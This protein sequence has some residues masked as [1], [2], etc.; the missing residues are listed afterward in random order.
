[1]KKILL[2]IIALLTMSAVEAQIIKGDMD[3]DG[4]ITRMD[5]DAIMVTYLGYMPTELLQVYTADELDSLYLR[6]QNRLQLIDSR[7]KVLEAQI[8]VEEEEKFTNYAPEH[9][10]AVDLG[11]SVRWAS[12]NLGATAPEDNGSYFAW[13]EPWP[14][15]KYELGNYQY[16]DPED[17]FGGFTKYTYDDGY[18]N[19]VWYD[20]DTF[21]GDSILQLEPMDDAAT[22]MWGTK[23]HIPTKEEFEELMTKCKWESKD[24]YRKVIGP[25]G[26]YIIMPIAGYNMNYL[27]NVGKDGYYWTSTLTTDK[28]SYRAHYVNFAYARGPFLGSHYRQMGISVRA[29]CKK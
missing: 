8:E 24:K 7:L 16:C 4:Q 1:M 21:I 5:A 20:G 18:K 27:S 3:G 25:N 28:E 12:C 26:N 15:R 17:V 29:V 11:L 13:G 9:V 14:K 22:Q 10:E 2:L 23:W 19:G 6:I